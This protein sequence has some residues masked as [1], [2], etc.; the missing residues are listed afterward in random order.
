MRRSRSRS[1]VLAV[2]LAL[3]APMLTPAP[4]EAVTPSG[5]KASTIPGAT[6]SWY[7]AQPSSMSTLKVACKYDS[8]TGSSMVSAKFGIHD[9]SV[10]MYHNG[11]ARTVTNTASI[12][13]GAT[14]F[15]LS[16]CAGITGYV[17]RP[18]TRVP[19]VNPPLAD[20]VVL[21]PR[22]FVKSISGACLVT[23]NKATTA[24]AGPGADI[25]IPAG[26]SFKIDNG[27]GRSVVDMVTN[28]TTLIT[29]ATA[30]FLSAP[31]DGGDGFGGVQ[32]LRVDGTEIPDDCY[33]DH[34]LNTTS[35]HLTAGCTPAAGTAQV[36]T[37]GGSL[38]TTTTRTANDAGITSATVINSPAA[39]FK[40]DDVGL[41]VYGTGIP[42]NTYIV[43]V[44][45]NNATT[46]G[47]MTVTAA[48]ISV[49]IGDPSVTAPTSTD[50][51]AIQGIQADLSPTLVAGLDSC[52]N[53]TPEGFAVTARWNNP[54]SFA[55]AGLTNAQPA[56]TKAIGQIFFDTSA[57]DY[58]AFVI[59]RG[60]FI[61]GD[62]TGTTHYDI[63]F[64]FAP[65]GLALCSSATSPGLGYALTV[66][67]TTLSQSA[68]PTGTGRPGTGQLRSIL[69]S[70][71]G[72]Y[73]ASVT[74]KSDDP[75][76][77]FTPA[78]EF[79]RLC[80]YPAGPPTVSFQCG[81]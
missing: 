15:T 40:T 5:C 77:T 46:T 57:A 62:P 59:E 47:G 63:V 53:D 6:I 19:I 17:N 68:L 66:L 56:G 4:A 37:I 26:S 65:T 2:A 24:T 31:D 38:L 1:V 32:G 54:G 21:A 81:N 71:T 73:A 76:V 51:V 39:K 8:A 69:P 28:G 22:T 49:T 61:S 43:S 48:P 35:A 18:I 27:S 79:T 74:V 9:A 36:L 14:T 7:P 44:S 23:L 3:L 52:A 13:A 41:P 50:M 29:S 67:A 20:T 60:A 58:S 42:A 33:I 10:A 64:S 25:P 30:N 16:S 11:A 12:A 75:L 55:G 80:I 78:S 72:G 34:V 70:A 45:G